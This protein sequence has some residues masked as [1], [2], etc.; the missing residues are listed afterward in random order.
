[1]PVRAR[2]RLEIFRRDFLLHGIAL[3]RNALLQNLRLG[4]EINHKVGCGN[5]WSE[6]IEIFLV[7]PQLFVVEVDVSENFIFLEQEIADLEQDNQDLQDQL[8]AITDIV[9]PSEDDD[10]DD[11]DENDDSGG[12]QD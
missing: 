3:F 1:M 2:D 5:R 10:S 7:E 12:D 11:D 6:Q 9:T 4:V 8:D